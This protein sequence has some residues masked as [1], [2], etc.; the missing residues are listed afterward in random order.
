MQDTLENERLQGRRPAARVTTARRA[1]PTVPKGARTRGAKG[2]AV[3]LGGV[4]DV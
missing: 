4:R 3:S 1:A 2:V